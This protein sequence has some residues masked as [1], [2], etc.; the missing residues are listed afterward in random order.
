MNFGALID[1]SRWFEPFPSP[2]AWPEWAAL[3]GFV[4]WTIGL[5]LVYRFRRRVFVGNGALIGMGTR[6]GP[7]G[8]SI[9]G[10]GLFLLGCRFA[11]VAYLQMRALLYLA[12]LCAVGYV[13][14]LIY[15]YLRRYPA[16]LAAVRADETRRRYI[17]PRRKKRAR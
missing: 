5:A 12:I 13:G 3:V 15:Y 16:V 11:S 4:L 10:L 2:V 9:G 1:L 17:P 6:F 7:Y 14:F 8:I